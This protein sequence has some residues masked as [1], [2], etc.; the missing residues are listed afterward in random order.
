MNTARLF[1]LYFYLSTITELNNH[2][3]YHMQ[4]IL[5]KAIQIAVN[6]HF[7]QTDKTGA[8]YIF[9]PLRVMGRVSSTE[10]RI[11]AVL[12]DVVED[13]SVTFEDLV[14]AG[15][16]KHLVLILRIL[17]RKV[18]TPYEGYIEK[19]GENSVATAVKIAD[20]TDNM[21]ASRLPKITEDDFT[22]LQKYSESLRYLKSISGIK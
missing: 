12:H 17:T 16:P 14:E 1:L 19:I 21:D 22:R 11:V 9:H 5:E 6:A 20:L 13:T 8:P 2:Y 3:L 10:E 18:D 7:G 15:I 4:E